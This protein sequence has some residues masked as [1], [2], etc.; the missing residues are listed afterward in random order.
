MDKNLIKELLKTFETEKDCGVVSP[1]I[2]FAKG[3]E[4]IKIDTQ[5]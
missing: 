4:S 3:H 5:T 2:Y 1:K